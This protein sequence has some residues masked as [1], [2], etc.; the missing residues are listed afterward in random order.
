MKGFFANLRKKGYNVKDGRM[1]KLGS[2]EYLLKAGNLVKGGITGLSLN[3]VIDIITP[4]KTGDFSNIYGKINIKNGVAEDISI[5]TSGDALNLFISGTYDFH[6]SEANMEVLGMLSKKISTMFGPLGN[7]S[8]NTLFNRIPWV[9]LSKESGLLEKINKI[10]G[11]E[12]TNKAYRKFL[13]RINGNINGDD[14]VTTFEWI[15]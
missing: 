7:M 5:S 14:Y 4:L 13:A 10:P 2:L 1:P 11:I 8:L 12:I 9:D 3:S 6:K 15:N